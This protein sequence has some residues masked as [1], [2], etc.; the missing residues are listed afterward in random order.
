MTQYKQG[1]NQDQ[2]REQGHGKNQD[3]SKEQGHGKNQDQSREQGHGKE[4]CSNLVYGKI[5]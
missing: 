2:S 5:N 4:L 1:Q 3:Q